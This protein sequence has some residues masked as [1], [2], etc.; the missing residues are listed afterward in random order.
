M[1]I[2]RAGDEIINKGLGGFTRALLGLVSGGF[3]LAMIPMDPPTEESLYFYTLAVFC[4]SISCACFF[5]G[6][7]RKFFGSIIGSILFATSIGYVGN[8]ALDGPLS[9]LRSE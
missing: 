8:Q 5:N 4:V 7:L 9:S 1:S 3:G 6:R 2:F